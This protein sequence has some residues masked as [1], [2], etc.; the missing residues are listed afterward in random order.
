MIGV[1][2]GLLLCVFGIVLEQIISVVVVVVEMVAVLHVWWGN[3]GVC[4]C[5]GMCDCD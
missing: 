1:N 4:D 2:C 5:G 3:V